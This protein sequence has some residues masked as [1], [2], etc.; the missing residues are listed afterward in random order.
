MVDDFQKR[1]ESLQIPYPKDT[2]T[3][4]IEKQAVEQKAAYEKFVTDSK[5]RCEILNTH[6]HKTLTIL[7]TKTP[8]CVSQLI[9]DFH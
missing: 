6:L 4:S 2:L 8:L 1:Y 7:L 5:S 9:H 3:A